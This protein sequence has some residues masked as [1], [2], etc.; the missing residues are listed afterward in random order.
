[1]DLQKFSPT[2]QYPKG[3][4]RAATALL[5]LPARCVFFAKLLAQP[6]ACCLPA[7]CQAF[8]CLSDSSL[9]F[10]NDNACVHSR[11]VLFSLFK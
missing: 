9:A 3:P 11:A 2:N 6:V 7:T 10:I 1:M 5:L 4:V 8:K